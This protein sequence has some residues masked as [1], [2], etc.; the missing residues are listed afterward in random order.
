MLVSLALTILCALA[1]YALLERY[2]IPGILG[3]VAIGGLLGPFGVGFIHP[4]VLDFS[5]E[6][7]MLAL[8]I[9]LLRAGL[10][11]KVVDLKMQRRLI[12][13]L[14]LFP[15][16][17]EVLVVAFLLCF[18][19]NWAWELGLLVG[20]IIAPISP[21]VVI[22]YLL[23]LKDDKNF[24]NKK[25]PPVLIASASLDNIW[26]LSLF[27]IVLSLAQ[28]Q[29]LSWNVFL[30]LPLS[31]AGGVF[32]GGILGAG[33]IY[34]SNKIDIRDTKKIYIIVSLCVLIIEV[35]KLFPFSSYLA[36]MCFALVVLYKNEKLGHRLSIKFSKLWIIAELLLFVLIGAQI[37]MTTFLNFE[38]WPFLVIGFG[39][40]IRYATINVV[41]R[42][43]VLS[44]GEKRFMASAFLPKAT[45]QAALGGIPLSLGIA[46]GEAILALS[47]LSILLSV[48]LGVFLSRFEQKNL[49]NS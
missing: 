4:K 36:V 18:F 15:F 27:G 14:S 34:F 3:F 10:S 43:E 39:L 42:R 11:L 31:V 32:V 9:I 7:K 26:A 35:G 45:I 5:S 40:F 29:S 28:S 12:V 30:E 47:I 46:G 44:L 24:L 20:M 22:P 38:Y 41:L 17:L 16:L 21:A 25:I 8:I 13:S 23:Q 6:F 1:L 2:S 37:N 49:K 33:F 19:F 48:P